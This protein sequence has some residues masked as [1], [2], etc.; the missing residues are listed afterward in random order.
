MI[1]PGDDADYVAEC[2]K[3]TIVTQGRTLDETVKHLQEATKLHLDGE[4]LVALGLPEKPI[5]AL[6]MD[7][8]PLHAQ[9]S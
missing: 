1:R 9:A 2:L 8:D 3:S 4:N 6:T 5:L 7:L